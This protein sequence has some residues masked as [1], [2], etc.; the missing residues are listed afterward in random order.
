MKEIFT[1]LWKKVWNRE[2]I[3]YVI[4]GVAT[5]LV[6]QI[7]YMIL[8][9]YI[10]YR[11]AASV[12]WVLAVLFAYIVNK[13]FV[14]ESKSWKKDVVFHEFPSFIACRFLSFFFDMGFLMFAVMCLAM[15][16]NWAKLVSNVF[17]II[18]N[19]FASKLIIFRKKEPDSNEASK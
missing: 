8:N 14:F 1:K 6:N 2:V 9:Y 15:N 18:A 5:T 10:D 11:I 19:Y 4:C 7:S 16:E 3:M 17:V 13:L 12:A